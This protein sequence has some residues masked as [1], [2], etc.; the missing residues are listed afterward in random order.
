MGK[1]LSIAVLTGALLVSGLL[2]G[3]SQGRGAGSHAGADR[4]P[5]TLVLVSG[6]TLAEANKGFVHQIREAALG[7]GGTRVGTIR[8]NC[9]QGSDWHCTIVY[10]VK[11]A[12]GLGQGTIV[13][14]GIFRGFNGESLAVT[15]GT[16]D[17]VERGWVGDPVGEADGYTHTIELAG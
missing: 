8:W 1:K 16:G 15:G 17:F 5:T 3:V 12:G 6:D 11:D 14:T 9:D 10:G 13:A 7:A 2:V 4:A